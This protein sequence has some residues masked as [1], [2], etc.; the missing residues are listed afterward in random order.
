[1]VATFFCGNLDCPTRRPGSLQTFRVSTARL[2]G[3]VWLC[4]ECRTS[5]APAW[6]ARHPCP[7]GTVYD[8]GH[9]VDP[10]GERRR[11]YEDVLY[12]LDGYG[13]RS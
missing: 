3:Q 6:P 12:R 7:C 5:D 4:H 10:E 11:V 9:S 1:M 8:H 13:G 2:D